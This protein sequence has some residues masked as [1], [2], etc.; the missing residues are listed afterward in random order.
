MMHPSYKK[1]AQYSSSA[2]LLPEVLDAVLDAVVLDAVCKTA[3][4][5]TAIARDPVVMYAAA[6]SG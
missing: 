4:S 2:S 5:K 3:V 1:E 6:P